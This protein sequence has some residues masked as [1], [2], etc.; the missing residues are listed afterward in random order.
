M[1]Q[2]HNPARIK[3]LYNLL[4]SNKKVDQIKGDMI[5]EMKKDHKKFFKNLDACRHVEEFTD[6]VYEVSSPTGVNVIV[7]TFDWESDEFS[8][9][10]EVACAILTS[11]WVNTGVSPHF[12]KVYDM[13][14]AKGSLYILY[15]KLE[16]DI[17]TIADKEDPEV[18]WKIFYQIAC[19]LCVMQKTN[20]IVHFDIR[21]DNVLVEFLDEPI[22]LDKELGIETDFI[23]KIADFGIAE[24]TVSGKRQVNEELDRADKE[25]VDHANKWGIFP[26]EFCPGYDMQYFLYTLID[27][28]DG[29]AAQH[30]VL[31]AVKH[32]VEEDL[33]MYQENVTEQGRPRV[34]SKKTG[35]DIKKYLVEFYNTSL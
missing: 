31:D 14:I 3:S 11:H 12:V 19:G 20:D 24:L 8:M 13:C 2:F 35:A 6:Q 34:V 33:E 29:F 15:E 22:V 5:K 21:S 7:K 25:N 23:V 26:E 10:N 17:E 16:G 4:Q 18:M 32:F 28:L 9:F 30:Y 1:A 27:V